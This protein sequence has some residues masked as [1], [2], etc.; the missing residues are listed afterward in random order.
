MKSENREKYKHLF[1]LLIS[2]LLVLTAKYEAMAKT[3]EVV[4]FDRDASET[5]Q[6]KVRL[7]CVCS[8]PPEEGYRFASLVDFRGEDLIYYQQ[9]SPENKLYYYY[10]I[11]EEK[12]VP[13]DLTSDMERGEELSS[14]RLF[15][16]YYVICYTKKEAAIH[17][18]E[19]G[20]RCRFLACPLPGTKGEK[21]AL[22]EVHASF[23]LLTPHAFRTEN[24]LVFTGE[25]WDRT[26]NEVTLFIRSFDRD[27]N[28]V[29]QEVRKQQLRNPQEQEYHMMVY[30]G[31]NA[32]R[33]MDLTMRFKDDQVYTKIESYEFASDKISVKD[34]PP[35]IGLGNVYA[36][37]ERFDLLSVIQ[38]RDKNDLRVFLEERESGRRYEIG[39]L[40]H[41]EIYRIL[42]MDATHYFIA[43]RNQTQR[44][45]LGI[46]RVDSEHPE[47][48][49]R[50]NLDLSDEGLKR[51]ERLN[52]PLLAHS[53]KGKLRFAASELRRDTV[54]IYEIDLEDE[55]E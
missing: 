12:K 4:E 8:L 43:Y 16:D 37:D 35:G 10:R 44:R 47:R 5:K 3:L 32:Q 24:R 21:K 53:R 51:Q 36:L 50:F 20:L 7:R 34:L 28:A 14:I 55:V 41:S 39:E 23:I 11:E 38:G 1:V 49:E 29:K 30:A 52:Q 26:K 13:L 19:P 40:R 25:D 27:L 9:E 45:H 54:D 46:L 6:A 33:A 22:F 15:G 31:N 48:S 42:P 18:A 2:V 17:R